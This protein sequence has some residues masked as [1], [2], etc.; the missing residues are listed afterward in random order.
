M[1][2][3]VACFL[4]AALA[5]F[6]LQ[7]QSTPDQKTGEK[8][9]DPSLAPIAD[10]PGLPRVLIIGDS[11][12]MGYTLRVRELLKGVAN[13][14]RIPENGGSTRDGLQKLD[15]WL[16]DGK[17][18]VIHFNWGLHDLKHWK[19]GKL[20]PTGPQVTPVELYEKNLREL[21]VK[22]KQTGAGLIF[23]TTTPIPVGSDGREAGDEIGYN[24]AARSV[25]KEAKAK[26]DD[27]YLVAAPRLGELQLP[28]N[29]HFKP[30]GYNVLAEQVAESIKVALPKN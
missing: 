4:G 26:I 6:S 10:V 13:V 28:N 16:G 23:A 9:V 25:M 30:S 21:M 27:L 20:D 11:I 2:R 3:F 19:D 29:V 15:R 7:A 22:L 5:T 14:H 12:S 8:K 24:E 1:R 18:D 17:W